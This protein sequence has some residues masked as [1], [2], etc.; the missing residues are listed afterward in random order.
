VAQGV[1]A[2]AT[3]RVYAQIE[4]DIVTLYISRT[5]FGDKLGVAFNVEGEK[6]VVGMAVA[7]D[8]PLTPDL[9]SAMQT[10]IASPAYCESAKEWQLT[11]TNPMRQC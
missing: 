1:K 10:Y 4:G 2:V 5:E 11:P 3:G 6:S 8:S 9:Q 7:K